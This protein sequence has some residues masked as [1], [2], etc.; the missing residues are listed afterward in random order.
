MTPP[1]KT[2]PFPRRPLGEKNQ[3]NQASR[4]RSRWHNESKG[5]PGGTRGVSVPHADVTVISHP[6]DRGDVSGDKQRA[7]ALVMPR[8]RVP[9]HYTRQR[10]VATFSAISADH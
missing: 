6:R 3:L 4:A 1:K 9:A 7:N 5:E 2:G 8:R 10:A